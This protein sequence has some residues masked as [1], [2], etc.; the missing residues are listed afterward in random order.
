MCGEAEGT[1][2]LELGGGGFQVLGLCHLEL[3]FGRTL[4][5]RLPEVGMEVCAGDPAL[6]SA[7]LV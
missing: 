5:T 4:G 1:G 2:F 6:L 7:W 3:G